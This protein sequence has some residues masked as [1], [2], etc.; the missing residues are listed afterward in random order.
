V[1]VYFDVNVDGQP[2]GRIVVQLFDDVPIGAQRFQD[3]AEGH[4]GISY[5]LSKF[6]A[7]APVRENNLLCNTPDVLHRCPFQAHESLH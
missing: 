4:E 3:I 7:I 2:K 6:D 1:Q 5:Q